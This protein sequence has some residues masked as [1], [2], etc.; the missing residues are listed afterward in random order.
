MLL[1]NVKLVY[2]KTQT[3]LDHL[4]FAFLTSLWSCSESWSSSVSIVSDYRLDDRVRSQ[5]EQ[6]IL[7]CGLFVQTSSEVHAA[8]YPM[9]T[10]RQELPGRDT[11][12]SPLSN[13]EVKN[14]ELYSLSPWTPALRS[15]TALSFYGHT[16][17]PYNYET[18]YW[19]T[20]YAHYGYDSSVIR[21][22]SCS[23]L[24]CVLS[25]LAVQTVYYS[26]LSVMLNI[27]TSF[28]PGQMF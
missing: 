22:Y 6:R 12:H 25:M 8:S 1:I 21:N 28:P 15:G 7:S 13:S 17:Y 23:H 9:G 19:V 5:A 27:Y 14:E 20:L 26:E 2:I 18:Q 11:D 4:V 10:E 3:F 24:P 16:I